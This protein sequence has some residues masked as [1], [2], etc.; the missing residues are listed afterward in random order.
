MT[1]DAY[2]P[3]NSTSE[4][5]WSKFWFC[6]AQQDVTS[7]HIG[8]T[9][10]NGPV[11]KRGSLP[12]EIAL[13]SSL[14]DM[15]LSSNK[16]SGTV[17]SE[18]G[19]L[20]SMMLL[21]LASTRLKGTIPMEL[22]RLTGIS[23]LEIDGKLL[24]GPVPSEI[25][26]LTNL[27]VLRLVSDNMSGPVPAELSNLTNLVYLDLS[28][29]NEITGSVSSSLCDGLERADVGELVDCECCL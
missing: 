23:I 1:G 25:G 22:S 9:D 29:E 13:L 8:L 17:P 5:D 20:E 27:E 28:G 18:L 4:C 3:D 6:N 2:S 24:E 11:A 26:L 15:H 12:R 16:L 19:E 14:F 10:L 7:I 21:S